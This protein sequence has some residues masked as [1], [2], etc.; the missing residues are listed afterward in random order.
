MV[1]RCLDTADALPTLTTAAVSA[2]PRLPS[3]PST[4]G[5]PLLATSELSR[6]Q[7]HT[8]R[9]RRKR[10]KRASL[11]HHQQDLEQRAKTDNKV[12]ERLDKE[13]ALKLLEQA[14]NVVIDE[15]ARGRGVA[16]GVLFKKTERK[17]LLKKDCGFGKRNDKRSSKK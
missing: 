3:T 13:K 5:R 4:T 10:H 8:E 9:L 15:S 14:Q 16:K 2:A 7:K 12:K 11:R 17:S 6:P 1:S